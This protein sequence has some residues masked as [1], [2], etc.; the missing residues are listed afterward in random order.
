[1]HMLEDPNREAAGASG[2]IGDR[3]ALLWVKHADHEV[4]DRARGEELPELAAEHVAEKLLEREALDVVAGLRQV[5]ALQ[6]L[7]DAAEGFLGDLQPVGCREE[8]IGRVVGLRLLKEPVVNLIIGRQS[9]RCAPV[10]EVDGESAV[11][12]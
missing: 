9:G 6:L 5:K 12:A 7:H 11:Q 2:G 3:L 8:I 10:E 1:M 4:H